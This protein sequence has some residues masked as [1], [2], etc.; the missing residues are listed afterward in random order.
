MA[1]NGEKEQN[2]A[3]VLMM[4]QKQIFNPLLIFLFTNTLMKFYDE[5]SDTFKA[6][7]WSHHYSSLTSFVVNF[8]FEMNIIFLDN[9]S[10]QLTV[11]LN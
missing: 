7:Y 4:T 1:Q 2:C 6:F 9:C 5:C 3:D 8:F 10:A 11:S